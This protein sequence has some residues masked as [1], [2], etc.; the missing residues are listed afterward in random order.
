VVTHHLSEGSN[1]SKSIPH[2]IP[3]P[4]CRYSI[5][6]QWFVQGNRRRG[7]SLTRNGNRDEGIG[8]IIP[9]VELDQWSLAMIHRLRYIRGWMYTTLLGE[10]APVTCGS[11]S[12][13][14]S[15][16]APST[17]T[18]QQTAFT[19]QKTK[20]LVTLRYVSFPGHCIYM[21]IEPRLRNRVIAATEPPR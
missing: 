15:D 1:F 18:I 13:S 6:L 7:M 14:R 11:V 5:T 8:V 21:V 17:S 19:I 3:T 12:S 20:L 10:L 2:G 4:A 16:L 9:E